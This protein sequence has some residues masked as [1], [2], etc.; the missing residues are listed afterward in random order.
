MEWNRSRW[1]G[2]RGRGGVGGRSGKHFGDLGFDIVG[3]LFEKGRNNIGNDRTD[4]LRKKIFV[5][6]DVSG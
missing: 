4:V 3:T 2:R 6:F 1:D 5:L